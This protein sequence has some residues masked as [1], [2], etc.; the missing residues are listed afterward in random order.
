MET[1]RHF[2]KERQPFVRHL[3]EGNS[4]IPIT[5]AW[6]R[7]IEASS[8]AASSMLFSVALGIGFVAIP[9]LA[10]EENYDAAQIGL[11]I[12]LAA[13][14]QMIARSFMGMLLR[15][16]PD[17]VFVIVSCLLVAASC[18]VLVLWTSLAA[19]VLSQLAQGVARAFFWTGIQTHAVR[20]ARTPVGGLA[21]MNIAGGLGALIG[22]VIAGLASEFSTQLA[23]DMGVAAGVLTLIPAAVLVKL[24]TFETRHKGQ[25]MLWR[26]P[27]VS[28]TC[29]TAVGTGAWRGVLNSYVPVAL[30]LVAQPASTIGILVA[31]ANAAT[32]VGSAISG[33]VRRAGINGSLLIGTLATGLGTAVIG[34]LAGFT[35][36]IALALIVSGIGA[37]ILQT[38][39]PAVA[40]ELVHPEERGDIIASVGLFRAA[41][42]FAAPAG[43][44]GIVLVAPISAAFV[45]AGALVMLPIVSLR[46]IPTNRMTSSRMDS[47]RG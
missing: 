19:F 2:C 32:L 25:G 34:I 41:A 15:R 1:G 31:I 43:M 12:A 13:V 26:R 8:N 9:L 36:A 47:T 20:V 14:S 18:G 3:T 10:L 39:G 16:A 17:K 4:T 24:P 44:A 11:L 21:A 33:W 27:G 40:T 38:V 35:V 22:P 46:S 5:T 7:R 37:G 6:G 29:W 30:A 28:A 23:L 45:V 42:L